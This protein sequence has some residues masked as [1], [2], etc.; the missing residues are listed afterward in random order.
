MAGAAPL[1]TTAEADAVQ[2]RLYQRLG[3][4]ERVAIMFR[5]NETVRRLA[6]AGMR[7][8]H[9]DYSDAQVQQAYARLVL[10]DAVVRAVW[11]DRALVDP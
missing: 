9:P 3:G 11:P 7:A 4:R 6:M 1:D 10:G 2:R 5:L 8:R